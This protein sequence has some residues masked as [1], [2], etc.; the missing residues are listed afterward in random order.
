MRWLLYLIIACFRKGFNNEHRHVFHKIFGV[1]L[2]K[3]ENFRIICGNY[4][5]AASH[6]APCLICAPVRI[7]PR[8]VISRRNMCPVSRTIGPCGKRPVRARGGQA[9][10]TDTGAGQVHTGCIEARGTAGRAG[11]RPVGGPGGRT[12][13]PVVAGGGG[14]LRRKGPGAVVAAGRRTGRTGTVRFPDGPALCRLGA[15]DLL[16]Q[17]GLLRHEAAG[18]EGLRAPSGGGSAAAGAVG[19]SGGP[20]RRAVGAGRG[21]RGSLRAGRDA[22]GRTAEAAD[23][24]DGGDGCPV[25]D[26]GGRVLPLRHD[27]GM[28]GTAVRACPLP[29]LHRGA[30]RTGGPVRRPDGRDAGASVDGGVRLR[31]ICG[32][33]DEKIPPAIAGT[34][35]LPVRG[36]HPAGTGRGQALADAV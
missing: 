8:A 14:R 21:G 27:G 20:Q 1:I 36:G 15:A 29:A 23:H 34:G 18:P 35:L 6:C 26:P 30:G 32:G 9:H 22:A 4:W 7:F 19:I 2:R 3:M 31:R 5:K 16:R 28:A 12:V 17:P 11:I 24:P 10:G 13:R 33:A 25:P